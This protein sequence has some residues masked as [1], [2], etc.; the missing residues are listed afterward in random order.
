MITCG[1]WHLADVMY[2]LQSNW[3]QLRPEAWHTSA[4]YSGG[5]G[6]DHLFALQCFLAFLA[7][8][9]LPHCAK[10]SANCLKDYPCHEK[11]WN[12][13]T[14][15]HKKWKK[16]YLCHHLKR[17]STHSAIAKIFISFT[18]RK[19]FMERFEKGLG[20][21]FMERSYEGEST[22]KDRKSHI[23]KM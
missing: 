14:D 8:R 11:F 7:W 1:G 5:G 2:L 18:S 4:W 13:D 21:A 6:D 16:E 19:V 23:R 12:S 15:K 3:V 9:L 22:Y 17:A 10:L 20:I